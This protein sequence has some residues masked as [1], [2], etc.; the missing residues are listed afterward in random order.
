VSYEY[1]LQSVI[2]LSDL[3]GLANR[4]LTANHSGRVQ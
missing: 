4:M 1:N 2:N 3:V